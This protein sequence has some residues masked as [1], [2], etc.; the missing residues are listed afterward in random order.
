M[1]EPIYLLDVNVL[2]AMV[3]PPHQ[4]HARTNLWFEGLSRP[5]WATCSLTQVALVRLLSDSSFASPALTPHRA[6]NLLTANLKRAGH[7]FWS[8]DISFADAIAPFPLRVVGH[9][10]V[11]DAYLLGLAMNKKGRLATMDQGISTLLS[12]EAAA[13]FITQV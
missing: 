2:L 1:S 13:A 12:K 9:K 8:S 5:R 7:Y 4:F 11:T 6:S 3:W 10:Q